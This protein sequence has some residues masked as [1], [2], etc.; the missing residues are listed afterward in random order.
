MDSLKYILDKFNVTNL[1]GHNTPII[2]PIMR[3]DMGT[4]FKE[5]GYTVGA[6]IGVDEG[7]YSEVLCKANPE[8]HLYCVDAWTAYQGYRDYTRQTTL[9]THYETAMKKLA[10]YNCTVIRKFSMDAVNDFKDQSLD[11]V[12]I[13]ASHEFLHVTEDI[14]KWSDKVRVGGIVSG[15]DYKRT[16]NAWICQVRDVVPAWTNAHKIYPWFITHPRDTQ[17][18]MWVKE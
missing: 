11:F 7:I 18:W 3:E 1:P 17:S 13:D 8:L 16:S 5:L 14:C 12:Y 6:E 10:P 4:L 15:H 2:L 9:N